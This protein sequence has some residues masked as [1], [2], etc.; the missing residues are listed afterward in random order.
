MAQLDRS[1]SLPTY[2]SYGAAASEPDGDL[3]K[4]NNH[5]SLVELFT[6]HYNLIMQIFH[7]GRKYRFR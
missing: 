5:I 2:R 3:L 4:F 1:L 6:L 7:K